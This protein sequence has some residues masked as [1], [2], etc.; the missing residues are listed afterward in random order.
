[1]RRA[2]ATVLA[3]PL[4]LATL[5]GLA[6]AQAE[7][8]I[9]EVRFATV[10]GV[11]ENVGEFGTQF[12]RGGMWGFEAGYQPGRLG[13]AW[14]I[15]W[16][17]PRWT[18]V[19]VGGSFD[20]VD[21]ESVDEE[22]GLTE[23]SLGLRLRWPLGDEAP[24]FLIASAGATALR[25]TIPIPPDS[26]REY[27]GPYLGAGVEQLLLGRYMLALEARYGMFLGGPAGLTINLSIAFG[28]R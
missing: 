22:V 19:L 24:R 27:I 10:V 1:M 13:V 23:M 9:P 17:V 3:I 26:T 25:A 8:D 7:S 28:S 2:V 6:A 4:V 20:S 16:S 11:R 12:G 18:A 5:S 21:A 15:G 14:S